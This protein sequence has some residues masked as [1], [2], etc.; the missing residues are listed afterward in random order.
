MT[1]MDPLQENVQTFGHFQALTEEE[2]AFL[3]QMAVQ[4]K[5]YPLVNCTNCKYCM[6]CPWGIDIPGIFQHYNKAITD[7]TY[8]QSREQQDY[9]RL[10][11]AYLV[12]YDRAVATVRQADH[13]IACA[14]C[15]SHCPQSIPIPGQLRR[16]AKY[17]EKLK[18]DTL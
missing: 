11:R 6:P 18:Q 1:N 16:I 13:C 12:S 3:E 5:E 17:V 14:E 9:A 2:L 4:M 8:A 7:G 15:V 10:K